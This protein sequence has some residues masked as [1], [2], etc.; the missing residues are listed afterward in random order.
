MAKKIAGITI[1]IGG[2]TAP[3][4]KALGEVNKTS[5]DLQSELKQVDRLLKLDPKNTELMAQKQKLL[6]DAVKNTGDKLNALKEAQ[7]QVN[8]QFAKGEISE[9]QY[10][11]FQREVIKTEEELKKLEKQLGQVNNKWKE[12]ADK[13][14]EFG[15]KATDLGKKLAPVSAAA[16]AAAA[17][18]VGLAVKAGQT[19]DDLN[20]L[21]KVTGL[22]TETL[23][24]FQYA[25]DVI[26]VSME[27]LTGSLAKLTRSMGN[28]QKGTKTSEEAFAKLGVK[29]TDTNGRLRDNEEVFNE[30]INALSKVRS[31]TERD[32]IAMELF[33]RSAQ[34]LNPLILGGADALKELGDEAERAGLILSQEALDSI[35]EFNDEIDK[36]KADAG[37]TMLQLGATIGEALLPVLEKLAEGLKSVMEWA[38]GLDKGTLTL[39]VTLAGIVAAIAPVLIIVGSF[40]KS[41]SNIIDLGIRLGPVITKAIDLGVKAGSA[42]AK[43][44][45]I[46]T[47]VLGPA[48]TFLTSPVGIAVAAIGA[49]IVAGVLLYKNW[50]KIVTFAKKM[51]EGIKEIFGKMKD[52]IIGI[53][54]GIVQGIKDKVNIVLEFVNKMINALNKLKIKLPDFMGGKEIGFNIK[55]IPLLAD[56]GTII[57]QGLA[58]V[59]E[60][61]PELLKLPQGAQVQPLDKGGIGPVNVYVQ[62]DDLQQMADVVR[63]FERIP[64]VAR[65]GV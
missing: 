31:E 2:N 44:G 27:T 15:E 52:F 12:T 13:V 9:E 4:N 7:K 62:A 42:I 38:R 58:V 29:I 46:L 49:L 50:E 22:T 6:T 35:N 56:G 54:E 36:L 11:A 60:R 34:E 18:M 14:G 64:Q 10:R 53:W 65:Q 3:L 28:A 21:S 40:A 47:K 17:G 43:L 55:N 19:A 57:K 26:D 51:W 59:G 39:I 37:A 33:G 48:L 25:S 45:G 23:Q 24:K 16:G 63:L 20:T 5:K 30:V 41:I 61:G 1:E 8:E 32:A